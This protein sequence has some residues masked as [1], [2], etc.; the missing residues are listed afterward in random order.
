MRTGL[1]ISTIAHGLILASGLVWFSVQPLDHVPVDSVLADVI[2]EREF[3]QLTAGLRTAPQHPRPQPIVDKPDAPKQPVKDPSAKVVPK[4]E[5]TTGAAPPGAALPLPPMPPAAAPQAS[6]A[7]PEPSK[8]E[9]DPIAE[10]LKREEAKKKEEAKKLEE[11]K[12]REEARRR[13][14]AKR[15]QERKFDLD[16]IETALLDKRAPQRQAA[17]GALV[18]ANASLGTPTANAPELSQWE[19]DALRAQLMACWYPPETVLQAKGLIVT[20]EF[21]LNRDGSLSGEP[22]VENHLAHP[23]FQVAA[24]TATRAVRSCQPFRLP[25][26]KYDAWQTVEVNFRPEDKVQN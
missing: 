14:E 4:P 13:E 26:S 20:V 25:V 1:T 21:S 3:S 11:A 16:K 10:A 2:S 18:N 24:E 9:P 12:K 15:Q 5:I 22:V 6:E 8:P 19:I 17:G 7:K 23:L